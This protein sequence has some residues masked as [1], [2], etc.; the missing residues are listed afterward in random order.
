MGFLRR[1][2]NRTWSFTRE[3]RVIVLVAIGLGVASINTGNNL[4]YLVFAIALSMI[5]LSGILSEMNIGHIRVSLINLPDI[6]VGELGFATIRLENRRRLFQGLALQIKPEIPNGRAEAMAGLIPLVKPGRSID[7]TIKIKGLRRGSFTIN[8]IHVYTSFP[9]SFFRKGIVHTAQKQALV[10]PRPSPMDTK[11]AYSLRKG[12]DSPSTGLG[13]QGEF[14]GVREFR[15]GDDPKAIHH[16]LSARM[17]KPMVR[18]FTAMGTPR[19]VL[20]VR[21]TGDHAH[22]ETVVSKTAFLMSELLNQGWTIRM[23]DMDEATGWLAGEDGM[24]KGL[25][26]LALVRNPALKTTGSNRDVD[27]WVD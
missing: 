19:L 14:W 27:F 23:T 26:F 4:L 6:T 18:E 20:G 2:F 12:L 5:V 10:L 13:R 24:L 21:N 16:R 25:R 8:A 11:P 17:N 1:H 7:V 15:Q 22:V 9:F 3:G